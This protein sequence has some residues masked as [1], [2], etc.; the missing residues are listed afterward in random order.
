MIRLLTLAALA[1]S[2]ACAPV[3]MVNRHTDTVPPQHT[4]LQ[5]ECAPCVGGVIFI[6]VGLMVLRVAMQRN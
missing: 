1:L 5:K 2:L 6:I 4:A 3:Q